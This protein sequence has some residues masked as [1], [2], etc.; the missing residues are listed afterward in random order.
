MAN[1]IRFIFI[2]EDD[3]VGFCHCVCATYMTYI[4]PP[5]GEYQVR[6]R[7]AF[8]CALVLAC[9]WAPDIPYRHSVGNQE[10]VGVEVSHEVTTA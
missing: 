10:W 8:L 3:L 4:D 9:A 7:N 1:L 5:I 2:E 6:R